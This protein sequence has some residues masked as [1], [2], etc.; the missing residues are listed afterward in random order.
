MKIWENISKFNA[1]NPVVTIGSFDGVHVGHQQVIA[2]LNAIAKKNKGESV[3]FTFS[4]H[5]V[6]VLHP[7]KEFV[8][9]TTIDEK[10]ELFAKNG[11]D[12]VVLFPFTKEFSQK[13][14]A[15]FVKEVLIEKLHIKTLL[16]GYDNTI[17]KNR[18]GNL[19]ELLKLSNSLNFKIAQQKEVR[20]N[21]DSLSSTQIRTLLSNGKLLSA[22]KLLGY[23]YIL[24][25]TVVHGQQIGNKLG[26]PTA[27]LLPAENK[28]IPGNGVYAILVETNGTSHKGMMNI[29]IRPTIENYANK[30]VIEAH[31]F[32]FSGNLYGKFIKI[33][34]IRKLRDEHKFNSIDAL[35]AQLKKDKIFALETLH[36]EFGID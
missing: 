9:L 4:P 34:V 12:H 28:F 21:D 36:K 19:G 24:S 22:S 17:G 15:D 1:K 8:L 10:L 20:L 7:D 27:N 3:I 33:S 18:E 5:P 25:G 11:V 26:F 35:R 32:D 13:T 2:Q 14:Y 29:G 16:V 6:K 30:A 23:H 31:L